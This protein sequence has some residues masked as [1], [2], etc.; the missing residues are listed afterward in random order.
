[1]KRPWVGWYSRAGKSHRSEALSG[2]AE[3]IDLYFF[4]RDPFHDSASFHQS[5]RDCIHPGCCVLRTLLSHCQEKT[6]KLRNKKARARTLH[7]WNASDLLIVIRILLLHDGD[8][9]LA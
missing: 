5:L 4:A 1:M 9:S 8:R 2:N 6:P 3:P 7:G